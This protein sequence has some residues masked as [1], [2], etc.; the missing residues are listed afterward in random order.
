[1]GGENKRVVIGFETEETRTDE[2]TIDE[3]E[4]GDRLVVLGV[5][6]EDLA[7]R[8]G[9]RGQV[10][11]GNREIEVWRETQRKAVGKN[12]GAQGVVAIDEILKRG[13]QRVFVERAAHFQSEGFIEGAGGFITELRGE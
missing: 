10:L 8:R 5:V 9:L 4:G 1:M 2:R 6:E 7:L 13:T 3:V 11:L 12:G